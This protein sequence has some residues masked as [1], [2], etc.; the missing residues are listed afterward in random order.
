MASSSQ[1]EKVTCN[2]HCSNSSNKQ[3]GTLP[4]FEESVVEANSTNGM[5]HHGNTME[6]RSGVL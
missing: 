1:T 3:H 6:K 4:M 5:A 2:G